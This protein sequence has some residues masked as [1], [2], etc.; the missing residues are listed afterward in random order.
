MINLSKIKKKCYACGACINICHSKAINMH[1]DEYGFS[2]PKI[3][4][5]KCIECG[6]CEKVC[7]INSNPQNTPIIAFTAAWNN[8]NIIK[9]ASGGMFASMATYI[10]FKGGVV[11]GCAMEKIQGKYKP[12]IKSANNLKDLQPL[13]GSKYV[14]A[15]TQN[16]YYE[17]QKLLKK[18]IQVLYSGT[19]CQISG[20]KNYLQRNYDNLITIDIICHGTPN[21]K[22]FQ[23]YISYIEK[24]KK[25]RNTK[26]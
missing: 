22:I 3:D 23:S 6:L 17:T 21:T 25:S 1:E 4:L 7:P 5:E 24:K 10:I 12:I 13:L 16:T 11:F 14:Q 15:D 18:G 8:K 9:C 20:L 19:P 2:Y 26:F